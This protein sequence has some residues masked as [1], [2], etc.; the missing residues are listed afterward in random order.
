MMKSLSR[1]VVGKGLLFFLITVL[2][3]FFS[4]CASSSSASD[5]DDQLALLV[6]DAYD[7]PVK[8]GTEEWEEFQSLEEML[9]VTQIPES[10]LTTMSTEGL[11]ETVF[12][13]PLINNIYA[14]NSVQEGF[15]V[16]SLRFNGLPELLQREDAGTILLNKYMTMDP[17]AMEENWSVAQK[18][19]YIRSFTNIE[20]LLAQKETLA[21]LTEEQ[22]ATLEQEALE[23]Y[24]G[25]QS[26]SEKYGP[27]VITSTMIL[28]SIEQL[29]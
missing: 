12:N 9:E 29:K 11:V 15:D 6:S 22:L 21:H 17:L 3:F 4:G 14:F 16:V 26:L 10:I 27:T 20:V 24:H 1:V 13:Y 5:D 19:R 8:A 18:G 25:K 7:F 2:A 28:D 23:K